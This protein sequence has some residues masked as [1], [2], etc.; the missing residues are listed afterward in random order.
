MEDQMRRRNRI[1]F[2]HVASLAAAAA[3]SLAAFPAIAV[4]V[5]KTGDPGTTGTA[6]AS[7][8]PGGN[9]GT[10][11]TGASPNATAL[12]SS[13]AP[14]N[15][16]TATGGN[17]GAGG[18]GGN[19][20]VTGANGGKGGNGAPGGTASANAMQQGPVASTI[21][22]SSTATGGNGGAGGGGGNGDLG[23]QGSGGIGGAGGAADAEAS[24]MNS[25]TD[26]IT[27][28]ASA[29]GGNGGASG[30]GRLGGGGGA[31]G[32]ASI[33]QNAVSGISNG[34]GNVSVTAKITGGNGGNTVGGGSAAG[35]GADASITNAVAASTTSTGTITLDQEAFGGA[36]GS[37]NVSNPGIG[38]NATSSLTFS[39]ISSTSASILA[40]GGTGGSSQNT[41]AAAGGLSTAFANF[42]ATDDLTLDCDADF[43]SGPGSV[44][45]SITAGS[46][47]FTAGAGGDANSNATASSTFAAINHSAL[48]VSTDAVGQKGGSL[49][50]SVQGNGG[51]GGAGITTA[52]GSSVGPD[53]LQVLAN[54]DGGTGGAG[55]GATFT[56]GNGGNASS[57]AIATNTRGAA[58][59]TANADAGF[60]GNISS[61]ATAGSVGTANATATATSPTIATASAFGGGISGA[62]ATTA[63]SPATGLISFTQASASAPVDGNTNTFAEATNH[64]STS[65]LSN[66]TSNNTL[67][68]LISG[69]PNA[70]D[71]GSAW[72][73]AS[74]VKADFNSTAANVN[75]LS[76]ITLEDPSAASTASHTYSTIVELNENN[77]NVLANGLRVGLLTGEP[78]SNGITVGDTIR[79]RIVRAGVTLVDHTLNNSNYQ[80]YFTNTDFEL[81]V[82]NAGLGAS[83]LDLQ[84][85]FDLTSTHPGNG[86]AA[87]VAVG[88]NNTPIACT[89]LNPSGTSWA[90]Q[91][92]WDNFTIPEGPGTSAIFSSNIDSAKTVTLDQNT[93]VGQ[94]SF[95]N[96]TSSYTIASGTGGS[97]FLDNAGAAASVSSSNGTHTISAPI[98]LTSPGVN[99]SATSTVSGIVLSGNVSG[100]GPVNVTAGSGQ[101][102]FT[103]PNNTYTGNTVVNSGATLSIGNLVAAGSLPATTNLISNGVTEFF[104][105]PSTGILPRTVAGITLSS[106]GIITVADP[107]PAV[108]AN[109]QVLITS[110]LTFGGTTNAWQ[111]LL[112]LQSNDM[113]VH[114]GNLTN[115][116]NQLAEGHGTGSPWS[117]SGG[118]GITSSAA[119]ATPT[120]TALAVEL[121]DDGTTAH[122]PLMTTFSGQ[123][124]TNTDVLVKYTFVGDADL[125]GTVSSTDYILIDSNFNGGG[126]KTGWRNGDFNYDGHINGDDYTL[127]D[128]A[129]NT[130]GST[131]FA[132]TSAGPAEMIAAD[133]AQIAQVPEPAILGIL[134]SCSLAFTARRRRF[135]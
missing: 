8:N 110:A 41:N 25:T 13:T 56:S 54:S 39:A 35:K 100:V 28:T 68:A 86:F 45:G 24:G 57:T 93:T 103:G 126:T 55:V 37:S 88:A 7:G 134:T 52:T 5:T 121:N 61:G 60:S 132:S 105:N 94:I 58:S 101:V 42:T 73:S 98:V 119:A 48:T 3:I 67:G 32:V 14:G 47:G 26:P 118:K 85:L 59:A 36:G 19:G 6:G 106:T 11:N 9:G 95:N 76:I 107:F 120:R 133:T 96:L 128:N 111:G 27:L 72:S 114:N 130:Q 108:H 33:A 91:F 30:T 34:G 125:S 4:T 75:A 29:I 10:G 112:D 2:Q 115:I 63:K 131:T 51:A 122:N 117:T 83:N 70:T 20:N 23:I 74:Q 50:N 22:D 92:D 69:S 31:G 1:L 40:F 87:E 44:G 135:R 49:L 123:P 21:T 129:F 18:N 113:I 53:T 16:A 46:N 12:A 109:R 97:L 66:F 17:E 84:L 65:S 77:V 43:I 38:G 124:V 78:I 127:I 64:Q 102:V 90:T 62:I 89:W 15:T 104:F 71:V 82:A 116:T 81:G 99:L 80:S 79:F